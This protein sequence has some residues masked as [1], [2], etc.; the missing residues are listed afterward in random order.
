MSKKEK[1]KEVVQDVTESSLEVGTSF[2]IDNL[3]E[4][5]VEAAKIIGN[6]AISATVQA[7]TGGVLGAIA[8]AF[9]GIKM[10]LLKFIRNS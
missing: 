6:D 4:L 8:P 9:L 7:L 5:G 3:P 1:I 2:V 10:P